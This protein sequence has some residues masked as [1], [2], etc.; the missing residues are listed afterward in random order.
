MEF[1]PPS[2]VCKCLLLCRQII[3][4]AQTGE[5]LLLGPTPEIHAVVFPTTIELS[6][7]ARWTAVQGSY[8]VE[9]QLQDL[10]GKVLWHHREEPALENY[11]PLKVC[12][13]TLHRKRIYMPRPGKFEIVMLANGVEIARDVF[14]AHMLNPPPRKA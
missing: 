14:F 1:K 11:D 9:M 6:V 12:N 7:F 4:D 13:L 5:L 10:E 3:T 2:P 8:I